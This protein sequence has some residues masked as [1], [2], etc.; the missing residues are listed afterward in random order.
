MRND[1]RPFGPDS[2][3]RPTTGRDDAPVDRDR[4]PA[5]DPRESVTHGRESHVVNRGAEDNARRDDADID[6]VMP[7]GDSTLPTKM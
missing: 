4:A 2:H 7:T 6:P 5:P 3:Q 1:A